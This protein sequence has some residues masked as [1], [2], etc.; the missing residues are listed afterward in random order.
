MTV[1][2]NMSIDRADKPWIGDR[3]LTELQLYVVVRPAPIHFPSPWLATRAAMLWSSAQ[4]RA[5]PRAAAA[6]APLLP[7][8]TL[9]RFQHPCW[10]PPPLDTCESSC[11][12]LWSGQL[13]L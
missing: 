9:Q 7:A 12:L 1:I 4:A 8:G 5:Q 2:Y 11:A 6:G 3:R 13:R 10:H